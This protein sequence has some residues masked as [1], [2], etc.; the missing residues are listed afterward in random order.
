[1]TVMPFLSFSEKIYDCN[2]NKEKI[3]N[4]VR[5]FDPEHIRIKNFGNKAR[6]QIAGK[7]PNGR[8]ALAAYLTIN[9]RPNSEVYIAEGKTEE[10]FRGSNKK[11]GTFIRALATRAAIKG[12]ARV[13]THKGVNKENLVARP[14]LE[15]I[16]KNRNMSLKQLLKTDP[17]IVNQVPNPIS[18]KIVRNKLG[19]VH[20]P[21]GHK[22]ESIF[23][24]NMNTAQLNQLLHSWHQK[25]ILFAA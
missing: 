7:T 5:N 17:S 10:P 2:M 24:N 14:F 9:F 1:M 6:I 23:R 22:H 3:V 13:V 16:A 20:R 15:K 25:N 4:F 19:F 18:T 11:Y 8:P 21:N 12:G